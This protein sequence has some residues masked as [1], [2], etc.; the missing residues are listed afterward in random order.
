MFNIVVKKYG[1]P[2][3]LIYEETES[4]VL[5]KNS[6]RIKVESAGVNFADLLIIKGRYQE[7]P[8]PPFSPGLEISGI[9][10]EIGS[11]VSTLKVGDKVMSIMKY[12]GYKTEVVVPKENTYLKPSKMGIL[13]AGGF[14]VIYGTAFS[15]IVTKAKLKKN[16]ICVILG[17]TGGVGMASI[18][19]AKA[20]GALVVA[21]GG[22]DKKLNLCVEKGA[23]Y[24]INYNDKIIRKELKSLG[25]NE[26]DV[27]IDMVGGQ[28]NLDLVK[29]LKWN[30]RIIIVGFTSG[31]IP[32]IPVN[33]LLLKNAR[34]EGLYW[35][36]LAY[37]EPKEIG[38]DFSVL[39]Q[40]YNN[41]KLNP[42]VNKVFE[43]K[44]ANKALNL[45]ADR[46]N[47]GKIVLKC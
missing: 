12:G 36:E 22:N 9:I 15:A 46:K 42:S 35:G 6:V 30:G 4:L 14:P 2:D 45:L 27:V 1:I 37:R 31:T 26:V 8:R 7:R 38:N 20:Y 40:L 25:I 34:A 11:N 19:I 39:E 16:E 10:S 28:S 33:R 43:L 13:E 18:E 44:D 29:S 47:I 17:A 41:K 24:T 3:N 32:A 21:C 5:D 23:D